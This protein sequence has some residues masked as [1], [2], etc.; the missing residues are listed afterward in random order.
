[1]RSTWVHRFASNLNPEAAPTVG[2]AAGGSGAAGEAI[3]SATV[4]PLA[5]VSVTT[6]TAAP[7][8]GHSVAPCGISPSHCVQI[9]IV[10][11]PIGSSYVL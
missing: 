10:Y 1:M 9:I 5:T 11:L 2:A 3:A 6:T 7:Q 4:G 8:C